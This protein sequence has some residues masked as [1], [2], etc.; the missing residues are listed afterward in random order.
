M[1]VGACSAEYNGRECAG[2]PCEEGGGRG[3]PGWDGKWEGLVKEGTKLIR[4]DMLKRRVG[5][6]KVR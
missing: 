4:K 1:N 5:Y 6:C 3:D 2:R